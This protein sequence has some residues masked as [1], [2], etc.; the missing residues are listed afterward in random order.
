MVGELTN[1]W[2]GYIPTRK[3][4]EENMQDVPAE[5][6][7]GFDHRGY[8]VRSALSR[9]LLPGC[10]ERLADAAVEMLAQ[11]TKEGQ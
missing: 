9:G 5:A 4:F 11:A 10:G 2:I 3:A 8:E 1:G 7:S 6:M